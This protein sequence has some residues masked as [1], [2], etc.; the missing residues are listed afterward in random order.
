M[1]IVLT[2]II[3]IGQTKRTISPHN[4]HC[5]GST[6][7]LHLPHFITQIRVSFPVW[8]RPGTLGLKKV[9][10]GGDSKGRPSLGRHNVENLIMSNLSGPRQVSAT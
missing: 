9:M 6:R 5:L 1:E 2:L 3:H 8:P 7:S 10:A 4:I